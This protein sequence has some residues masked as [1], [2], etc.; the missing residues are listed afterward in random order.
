M[1][2]MSRLSPRDVQSGLSVGG[3]VVG[4]FVGAVG[5][6]FME[7]SLGSNTPSAVENAIAG[8]TL[9]ATGAAFVLVCGFVLPYLRAIQR[10]PPAPT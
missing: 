10:E 3:T 7:T 8:A 4:L 5:V 6:L 2:T 9:F 1:A